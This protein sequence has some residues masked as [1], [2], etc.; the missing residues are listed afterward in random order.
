MSACTDRNT[1]LLSSRCVDGKGRATGGRGPG[2]ANCGGGESQRAIRQV[3]FRRSPPSRTARQLLMNACASRSI[4]RLV[5]RRPTR[6]TACARATARK[7]SRSTA[8][9]TDRSAP[10][11]GSLASITSAP[12]ATAADASAALATLTSSRM[13]GVRLH[14][15]LEKWRTC[16][17]KRS[18]QA[19]QNQAHHSAKPSMTFA[20]LAITFDVTIDARM[21]PRLIAINDEARRSID[22]ESHTIDRLPFRVG[23]ES[24]SPRVAE[25][26]L[27]PSGEEGAVGQVNDVY[28]FGSSRNGSPRLARAFF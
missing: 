24:R 20:Q 2:A 8:T 19:A 14:S 13:T 12:P 17:S 6:I 18:R 4:R 9:D 21:S 3:C 1:P 10:A 27:M 15:W 5:R 26:R 7:I 16:A 22:G 28:L 25:W 11:C 23:R